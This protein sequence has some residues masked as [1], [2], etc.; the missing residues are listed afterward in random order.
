MSITTAEFVK[1][2]KGTDPIL[3]DGIMHVAFL[4]RSNVGKSSAIN[5]LVGR[6]NLVKS[7]STPGKTTELNF[8]RVVRGD[9]PFYFVDLPGYGFARLSKKQSEKLHKMIMW[10]VTDKSIK[11][12]YTVLIIDAVVGPTD[13][14][15][16]MLEILEECGKNVIVVANKVDKIPKTK[17]TKRIEEISQ[18]L[19]LSNI[20]AYSAKTKQGREELLCRIFDQV[21]GVR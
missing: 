3:L 2:I 14:D 16:E 18:E 17:Q 7:S 12:K 21:A 4:G 13:L 6:K 10:Y 11:V 8:F 1:G 5:T 19:G 15:K 20:V 9:K